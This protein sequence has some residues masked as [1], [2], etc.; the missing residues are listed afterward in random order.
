MVVG[1]GLERARLALLAPLVLEWSLVA[2]VALV[3]P[4][5]QR[6]LG[7]TVACS[8]LL[9]AVVGVVSRL[10]MLSRRLVLGVTSR[11]RWC[12]VSLRLL[13]LVATGCLPIVACRSRCTATVVRAVVGVRVLTR[14]RLPL[15]AT[16]AVVLAAVVVVRLVAVARLVLVL[17]AEAVTGSSSCN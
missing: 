9:V 5:R 17:V 1:A 14:I 10:G 7:P 13:V 4:R 2:L 8:L 3:R 16:A 12:L 6:P 11:R 15:A